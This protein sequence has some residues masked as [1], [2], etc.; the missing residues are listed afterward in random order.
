MITL[1][2]GI[3][4]V[5][6]ADTLTKYSF[7]S[8][9]NQ[10]NFYQSIPSKPVT[11]SHTALSSS[12]LHTSTNSFIQKY[13]ISDLTRDLNVQLKSIENHELLR[14]TIQ[15]AFDSHERVQ[16]SIDHNETKIFN[17]LATKIETK[18]A[19]ALRILNE[20]NQKFLNILTE[21]DESRKLLLDPIIL[22]CSTTPKHAERSAYDINI[23]ANQNDF[24][25]GINKKKAMDV[26][27]FLKNTDHLH[28]TDDRNFKINKRLMETLKSIDFS[29]ANV[30]SFRNAFFLPKDNQFSTTNCRNTVPNEHQR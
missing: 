30:P 19:T 14:S 22:P 4:F 21:S 2:G 25:G 29:L 5:A 15:S 24:I 9:G 3:Q 7:E 18:L 8:I 6:C 10:T 16:S 13:A 1:C 26:S 28:E 12:S 27:N 17:S 20:T 11:T 23:D